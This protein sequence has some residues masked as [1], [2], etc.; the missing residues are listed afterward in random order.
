M[1][2]APSPAATR[3]TTTPTVSGIPR[4]LLWLFDEWCELLT[5]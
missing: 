2:N 1:D 5:E 3:T 4:W